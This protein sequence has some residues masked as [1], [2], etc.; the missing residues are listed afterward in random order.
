VGHVVADR[1]AY[2]GAGDTVMAGHVAGHATDGGAG[3]APG[4]G[5]T[6]R[7][8]NGCNHCTGGSQAQG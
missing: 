8:S 2:C 1:A 3:H 4:L 6:R 7:R 5:G